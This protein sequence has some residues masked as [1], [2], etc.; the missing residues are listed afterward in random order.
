M[1]K[2]NSAILKNVRKLFLRMAD[3]FRPGHQ[4]S[5]PGRNILFTHLKLFSG[6]LFKILISD[7]MELSAALF[8]DSELY[9]CT[10]GQPNTCF[11]LF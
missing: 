9:V 1:N 8:M 2:R 3:C 4:K 6:L 11:N 5:G 10:L 7:V